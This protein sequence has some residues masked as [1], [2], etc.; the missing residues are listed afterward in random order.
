MSSL[1]ITIAIL[2]ILFLIYKLVTI[3]NEKEV[4]TINDINSIIK[5]YRNVISKEIIVD[6]RDEKEDLEETETTV[7]E[8]KSH[9]TTHYYIVKELVLNKDDL[10]VISEMESEFSNLEMHYTKIVANKFYEDMLIS[11]KEFENGIDNVKNTKTIFEFY[12]VRNTDLVSDE[13]YLLKNSDGFYD[14]EVEKLEEFLLS[15]LHLN[16]KPYNFNSSNKINITTKNSFL[17]GNYKD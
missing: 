4:T 8:Q 1:I 16:I 5:S 10:S 9:A 2:I 11:I 15:T 12:L 7:S 13:K 6:E 3:K 17:D 14:Q